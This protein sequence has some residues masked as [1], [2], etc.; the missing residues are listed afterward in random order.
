MKDARRLLLPVGWIY[1]WIV[2]IRNLLFNLRVLPSTGFKIA[3]ISVGNLVAG[4][5]GKS[6]HSIYLIK[7]LT[8]LPESQINFNQLAV[9]SRGYGRKTAGYRIISMHSSALEAGDEML[10][11]KKRYS[12]LT[13]AVDEKRVRGVN[14]LLETNRELKVVLLDDAFQ[15]RY[16]K[17]GLS[18]LLT[19]YGE[20]FY[21]D[22][23]LPAGNLREFKKGY[24]RAD[25]IVVTYAPARLTHIEKKVIIKKIKPLY[26]QKVF[27]SNVSYKDMVSL[28]NDNNMLPLFDKSMSIM[29]FTGIANPVDLINYLKEKVNEVIPLNFPDHHWFTLVDLMKIKGAFDA[30]TNRNKIII[31]TEKDAARLQLPFIRE[32]LISYPVY[33]IPVEVKIDEEKEFEKEII[34]SINSHSI[35]SQSQP[36]QSREGSKKNA[37]P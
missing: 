19:R 22:Y 15:H 24:K 16:I 29:V 37:L 13:V 7:L 8:G 32:E 26:H 14:K 31:T 4:G 30:I 17:P 3:T 36:G 6:P 2:S 34:R 25:I 5:T 28:Y 9:L 23:M 10:Q 11:L 20:P 35:P 33:Y 18:I 27:F 1:G 12:D 21:D